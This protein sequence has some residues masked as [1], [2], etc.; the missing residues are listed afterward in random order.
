METLT[1]GNQNKKG[2]RREG[3]GAGVAVPPS[4]KKEAGKRVQTIEGERILEKGSLE[5][6]GSYC[7]S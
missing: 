2:E 7:K 5:Y 4:A 1:M 6:I 3:R